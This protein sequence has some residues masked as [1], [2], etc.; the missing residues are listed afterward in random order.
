[1]TFLFDHLKSINNIFL[2]DIFNKNFINLKCFDK[3]NSQSKVLLQ[4][5]D[6]NI[7]VVEQVRK[8]LK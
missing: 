6:L 5:K 3:R 4:I 8:N 1:M 2:K 7:K